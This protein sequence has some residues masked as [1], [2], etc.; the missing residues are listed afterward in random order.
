MQLWRLPSAGTLSGGAVY[1]GVF[2]LHI[3]RLDIPFHVE[4]ADLWPGICQ[5]AARTFYHSSELRAAADDC[6]LLREFDYGLV[7]AGVHM[8][9]A[10]L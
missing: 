9:S 7:P 2:L 8:R 5:V 4:E 3:L 6:C 10:Q 1:G